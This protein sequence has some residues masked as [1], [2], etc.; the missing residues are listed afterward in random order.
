MEK[1]EGGPLM[2]TTLTLHR[3]STDSLSSAEL[4]VNIFM[5]M[6]QGGKVSQKQGVL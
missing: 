5:L 2:H 1:G 4:G 3:L 6:A